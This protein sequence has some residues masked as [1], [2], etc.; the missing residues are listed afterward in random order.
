MTW[1]HVHV[2]AGALAELVLARF[3]VL[4][5]YAIVREIRTCRNVLST[6]SF[7]RVDVKT[8]AM[9]V[10][11]VQLH[12]RAL[13]EESLFLVGLITRG[14]HVAPQLIAVRRL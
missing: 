14:V 12:Q 1:Y 2:V 9:P 6:A 10:A 7:R 5:E 3:G 8:I 13:E 11:V 4:V